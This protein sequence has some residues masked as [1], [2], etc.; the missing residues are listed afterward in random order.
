[1]KKVLVL[2][3][4]L[5]LGVTILGSNVMAQE[6]S[7]DEVFDTKE[8]QKLIK[9]ADRKPV[10]K[11][12]TSKGIGS[13]INSSGKYPTRK[14]VILVTSDCYKGLIPTGHAAIVYSK[15]KVVESL[16]KGVTTG[17]NNWNKS[18]K[19]CYG[20]TTP[21]TTIYQDAYVA[22]WCYSQIGKKYNYNYFNVDTRNKFYCSQLVYAGYL[23]KQL[24]DLNTWM[25]GKAIHPMELVYTDKTCTIYTK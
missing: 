2:M 15:K 14:G 20:V 3:L 8:V 12:K 22:D 21:K 24:I 7:A 23:D 17:K 6:K 1:M 5:F 13:V 19:K 9:E 10:R 16:S 18:K 4:N 11:D 25:F